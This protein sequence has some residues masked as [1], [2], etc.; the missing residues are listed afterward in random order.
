MT[1]IDPRS[2]VF[3]HLTRLAAWADGR[4]PVPVT[5]EWDLSNRCVLG[6]QDCHFAHTHVR[7]PWASRARRLPMA[8]EGTG[9]LADPQLVIAACEQMA[10]LGVEG[11]V[12]SGGGEPTT[13]PDLLTIVKQAHGLGIRQGMYSLGALITPT[14]AATLGRSL[15]WIVISLDAADAETYALEKG[16]SPA[17]FWDAVAGIRRLCNERDVARFHD[18]PAAVVGVS[19]LLHGDN[20]MQARRM[21]AIA[22]Q[23]GADYTT[24]RPAIRFSADAPSQPLGDRRWITDALPLLRAL[25]QD[26]SIEIDA[27]RFEQ[28]RDWRDHGYQDCF[29]VR[30]TTTITPDGRVWICPQRRGVAGSE[31]GD[32]RHEGFAAIWARHPG[33]YRVDE[34]C[35]AMCR[36]H[37]MNEQLATVYEP[38]QHAAFL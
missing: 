4:K 5:I 16:V 21:C 34:G 30:L 20:W 25:E 13:H 26:T 24:F 11:I 6:C 19:F 2:K 33:R 38:H 3:A 18:E 17:R 12:W 10:S 29:G 8:F 7:G 1:Y 31:L 14:I 22:Q 23:M 9:D 15:D 37:L 27:A 35:R 32:L 28:Y 36:L